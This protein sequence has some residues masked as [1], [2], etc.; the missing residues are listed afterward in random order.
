MECLKILF[1]VHLIIFCVEA[2]RCTGTVKRGSRGD[3]V[4][5]VQRAVG[6]SADGIFGSNTEQAVRTYQRNHRLSSDGIVGRNTWA[7]IYG[8]ETGGGRESGSSN[9]NNC[10]CN[11]EPAK[12]CT[13]SIPNGAKNLA[14]YLKRNYGGRTEI[15]NCRLPSL[16]SEGRAVDF[17][18]SKSVGD[19]AFSH[20]INIACSNGI[21]EVIWYRRRWSS[22]NG[23]RHYTGPHAHTA[24]S[25]FFESMRCCKF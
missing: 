18:V 12:S 7:A 11:Y 13:G 2:S 16:H 25:R 6:V 9:T 23:I 10:G 24:R 15:L 3:C 19:R 5:V 17:Y 8:D 21:Q 4:K 14:N 20:L 22:A 1:A